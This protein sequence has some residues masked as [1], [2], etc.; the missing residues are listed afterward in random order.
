[1]V[2]KVD[3]K[4]MLNE[5]LDMLDSICMKVQADRVAH[6]RIQAS[7][8]VLRAEINKKEEDKKEEVKEDGKT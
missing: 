2:E 5:A 4:K 3:G 1:M 6:A 7:V 8:G